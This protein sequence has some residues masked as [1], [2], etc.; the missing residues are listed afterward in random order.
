MRGVAQIYLG[1][2][3][4]TDRV[5]ALVDDIER[6]EEPRAGPPER[7]DLED[8][9]DAVASTFD[10]TPE[11]SAPSH[12]GLRWSRWSGGFTPSRTGF[13]LATPR[14]GQVRRVR[15]SI[16]VLAQP[17][18]SSSRKR[19]ARDLPITATVSKNRERNP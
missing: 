9:I 6:S 11:P 17:T 14:P 5:Q 7:P 2:A 13:Q 10:T 3:S 15:P 18:L 12:G 4:W 1:T 19:L 16:I 8:V